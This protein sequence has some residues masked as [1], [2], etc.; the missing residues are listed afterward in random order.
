MTWYDDGNEG[1][2]MRDLLD[3]FESENPGIK[4]VM[5]T[6]AYADLHNILQAQV[7]AGTPPDL[8]RITDAQR[9][10][11]RYLDMREHMQDPQAWAANWPE[12]RLQSL[13]APDDKE[14]LYGF[15]MQY[16][17][18]GMFINRTLFEQAGVPVPSDENKDV[19]WQQ[20][21][22]AAKQVAKATQT[23]YAIAIDRTGHRFWPLSLSMCAQY[24]NDQ[25][26]I[27]VD[28]PGFREAAN[29]LTSW[30]KDRITPLEVWA[31][32]GGGYAAANE[33]FVNGQTPLYFSGSWQVGQFARQIG[34]RFQWGVVPAPVGKCGG[35]AIP[36]GA[37]IA[38]F[39]A[40]QHPEEVTRLVEFLSQEDVQREFTS[41]S[42][43]LP[44]HQG[45]IKQGVE[46]PSNNDQLNAFIKEVPKIT[47][48]AEML[49]VH[50]QG[51]TLNTTIRDRLSQVIV[52]ELTLD[53][54]ITRIQQTMDEA[55]AGKQ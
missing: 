15:P 26:K 50:P 22:D 8:A 7:E 34:D 4:V 41:R 33:F 17:L 36:G 10:A 24:F 40:T 51:F 52:G 6:I 37:L 42:L 23:P 29:M 19:T 45:L 14:G 13:R 18:T 5:D 47:K 3:R 53:E 43:F 54:A 39:N 38:A 44:A 16:T 20:W 2:V 27:T 49:S 55:Q 25:G 32:G 46:Y 48:E 28:T 11:G 35:T 1:Q 21:V 12:S 30:H 9:F 31:G